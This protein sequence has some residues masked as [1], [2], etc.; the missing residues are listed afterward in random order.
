MFKT[1]T[2]FLCN[3]T[4]SL[5][6]ITQ[7]MI[8]ILV[9]IIVPL[10]FCLVLCRQMTLVLLVLA[11]MLLSIPHWLTPY[12][13]QIVQTFLWHTHFL[14]VY[15]GVRFVVLNATFNNIPVISWRSVFLVENTGVPGE[16][17]QPAASPWRS[18]YATAIFSN[19]LK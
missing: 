6:T 9:R 10:I 13:F 17:R 2:T 12:P 8:F 19:R 1:K 3:S 14:Y 18:V 16:E 4:S 11:A 15:S 7:L 5:S